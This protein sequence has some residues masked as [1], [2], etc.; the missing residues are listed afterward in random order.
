MWLRVESIRRAAAGVVVLEL[1]DAD[2]RELP[3][4]EPG[5]H[6]ELTLPSG[7]VR[8]YSLCGPASGRDSYQVAVLRVPDGRGGSASAGR[9][10]ASWSLTY[11]TFTI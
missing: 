9:S 6:L 10:P 2:G 8:H 11:E 3:D 5:R 7:L 4:W 1:A